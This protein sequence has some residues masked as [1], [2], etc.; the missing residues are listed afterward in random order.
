VTLSHKGEKSRTRIPD[1]RSTGT[2]ASNDVARLRACNAELEKALAEAL[3]LLAATSEVL[4]VISSS[5]GELEPVFKAMLAK[6]VR[7]CEAK[8]GTMYLRDADTFRAV[9]MHNAP[10]GY[11]EARTREPL[12]PPPDAPLGRVA[13]T[14]QVVHI[15]DIKTIPS[16][17]ERDPFVVTA[18]DLAGFRTV[19]AVPML[20]DNELIGS[21]NINRQE[22]RPFTDRQIELVKHFANQAV[23]AI[24]NTRLLNELRESL[25]QQTATADVLKVISSSPGKLEPVFNSMLE[26][27]ARICEAKL[28]TMALRE[29]DAFR[30]VALHNAPPAYVEERRRDPLIHPRPTSGLGRLAATR[31]VVHIADIRTDQAYLDGVP[32]TVILADTAGARTVVVVPMLKE[33]ELVGAI[34]IYRQ[35]VYGP[36]QTSR[37]N[38][39]RT[40]PLR[41]LS[42]SRTP[43]CSTNCASRS[44]SRQ[45]PPTCSRSSAARP[46]ICRPFLTRWWSQRPGCARRTWRRSAVRKRTATA[47]SRA[48]VSRSV[49][50]A[51]WV[52]FRCGGIAR[53]SSAACSSMAKSRK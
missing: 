44:S 13:A 35:E 25:Q 30:T 32:S 43:A 48:T 14:K 16:Y 1:V 42:P 29:G 47:M 50:T 20:K 9:A 11:A 21:I 33:E 45:P 41:P 31:R 52:E 3:A 51:R 27:A 8:F 22:V 46:S 12:R 7:I 49:T 4:Q 26:N 10:P 37:S 39:S 19:L 24:E 28:G 18:V 36:S 5:P 23:I 53:Q 34:A 17:I 38:S 40:S 2:N 6:A 15:T